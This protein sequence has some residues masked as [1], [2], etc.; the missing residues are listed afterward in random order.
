MLQMSKRWV[1][2]IPANDIKQSIVQVT[3][4][5]MKGQN[6]TALKK[7]FLALKRWMLIFLKSGLLGYS[8]HNSSRTS[9]T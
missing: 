1:V 8:S 6:I 5:T 4:A 2:D 7:V 9:R 3:S